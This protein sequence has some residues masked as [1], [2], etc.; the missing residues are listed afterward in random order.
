MY[1]HIICIYIYIER[2][3]E[4]YGQIH[5]YTHRER[6]CMYVYMYVFIYVCMYV[7]IYIRV[8]TAF[9]KRLQIRGRRNFGNTA[10]DQIERE[11]I[12]MYM[13]IYVCMYTYT[14]IYNICIY[15]YGYSRHFVSNF[16]FGVGAVLVIQHQLSA[17][18]A[19]CRL[20]NFLKSQFATNSTI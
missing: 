7:C 10:L 14:Y 12:R 15:I 4:R 17:L 8:L 1:I 6:K 9:C 11:C 2:Y 18:L 13:C 5:L 3:L 16:E 20:V 19:C